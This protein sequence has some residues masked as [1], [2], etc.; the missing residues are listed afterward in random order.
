MRRIDLL[1]RFRQDWRPQATK[2]AVL[3]T[4]APPHGIGEV[5]D[6]FPDGSPDGEDPLWLAR[7]MAAMGISLFMVAC[8]P[9]LSGYQHAVDF[10][11][12]LVKVTGG[13]CVPLTTA[14]LLSHVI[15]A[16]AG[17]AMDMERL[18]K[19]V[20]DDVA[21]R[22]RSLSLEQQGQ[23]SGANGMSTLDDVARELHE[24]LLLRNE[25]TKQLHIESIYRDSDGER[26]MLTSTDY[27]A[28]PRPASSETRHNI[29]IWAAAP[30]LATARPHIKR[31]IGSRLSDKYLETRRAATSLR[32]STSPFPQPRNTSSVLSTSPTPSSRQ[33]LSNFSSFSAGPGLSVSAS[34]STSPN[35][36]QGSSSGAF[37]SPRASMQ[38]DLRQQD[39]DDDDDDDHDVEIIYE[40]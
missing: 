35:P 39:D 17:E 31:V 33:V 14:S 10:Y 30:N 11:Q 15:V 29:E 38:R 25:S 40:P 32:S 7:Q 37:T 21:E 4:D 22:L 12:G 28:D 24:K 23:G 36:S 19:D 8:E 18:H 2:L 6:G 9:A 1:V 3:I 34:P 20:G 27:P 13:M 5:G 16:A 26:I